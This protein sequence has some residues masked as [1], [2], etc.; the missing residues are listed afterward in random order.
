M[1]PL[2]IMMMVIVTYLR[3]SQDK[4]IPICTTDVEILSSLLTF[5]LILTLCTGLH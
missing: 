2:L 5:E 1:C 4:Q 3:N